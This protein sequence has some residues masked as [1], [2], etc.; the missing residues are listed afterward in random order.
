M[1]KTETLNRENITKVRDALENAFESEY[2]QSSL[3]AFDIELLEDGTRSVECGSPGCIAG[4][5]VALCGT[6]RGLIDEHH[7]SELQYAADLLFNEPYRDGNRS[8][9]LFESRPF[10]SPGPLP[11]TADAVR[12]LNHLLDTG[13]VV[14]NFN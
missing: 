6:A 3:G 5:A 13:E 11:T 14:W 8:A 2:R 12:T 10:G 7:G 9:G 1:A 4:W